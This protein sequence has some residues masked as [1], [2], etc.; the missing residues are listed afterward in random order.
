M[1]TPVEA[2]EIFRACGPAYRAEHGHEMPLRQ[3]R[4]MQAVETCR[5]A[6]LGGYVERCEACG[7]RNTSGRRS[8][9]SRC[10][11]LGAGR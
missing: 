7:N 5:T 3:I 9:S 4:A 8:A 6:A 2:G 11:T 1:D 10:C